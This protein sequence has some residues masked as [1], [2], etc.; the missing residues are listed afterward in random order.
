[1]GLKDAYRIFEMAEQ[2]EHADSMN[3]TDYLT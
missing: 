3:A 1:M 2:Q